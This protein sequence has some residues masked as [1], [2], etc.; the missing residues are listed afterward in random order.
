MREKLRQLIKTGYQDHFLPGTERKVWVMSHF[1]QIVS[2]VTQL[3]WTEGCEVFIKEMAEDDT[4]LIELLQQSIEIIN[5]SIEV[6]RGDLTPLERSKIIALI[7]TD[8]H[9]RDIIEKLATESVSSLQDFLWQ[10]QLRYY[11]DD[12]QDSEGIKIMQVNSEISYGYEYMGAAS[13]LVVT[14]LTERCYLTITSALHIHLGAAPAGPAGTGKTETVKDLSKACAIQCIVFNCSEQMEIKIMARLFSG[15]IQQGAWSCLDEFNRIDIEVLSVIAQQLLMIRDALREGKTEI[16]LNEI[17][18]SVKESVGVF[19]TMNPNYAGRTELPDNLKILFRPIA[20]MIPDYSLIAEILLFAQGFQNA[21]NL[22][23]KMTQ[24]YKLASEQLSQQ[25][26]YD[27]GM[28]A[29][30]SVLVIAGSLKK[31]EPTLSEDVLLI[32]AMRDA[33]VPKFLADDL[34]LFLQLIQDLFPGMDIPE[35][36]YGSLTEEINSSLE[37][38]DYKPGKMFVSKVTQLFESLNVRFGV[39][40]L[41]QPGVGKSACI[42]VLQDSMNH[43]KMKN[44]KD[45]RFQNVETKIIFPK[46]ISLGEL[47]GEESKDTKEWKY[48]IASKLMKKAAAETQ[49]KRAEHMQPSLVSKPS[50]DPE[51]RTWILMDGPVDSKWIENMNSVLDDSRMLCLA[52]AE[53]IKLPTQM[54]ILFEVQDLTCASLATVSRCGMVYICP[55]DVGWKAFIDSWVAKTNRTSEIFKAH[56]ELRH[57]LNEMVEECVEK[58]VN[59]IEKLRDAHA[60]QVDSIQCLESFINFMNFWICKISPADSLDTKK[61]KLMAYFAFSLV[62][63]FGGFI[64]NR[65]QSSFDEVVRP[66]FPKLSIPY[67]G[68]IFDY[69]MEL[70]ES[71]TIRWKHWREFVPQFKFSLNQSYFNLFVPTSDSVKYSYIMAL[72]VEML[73][74]AFF[75]GET[76]V[77]KS[78]M[79]QHLL[80]KKQAENE[81]T[82]TNIVFSA[83]TSSIE[84]QS[85]IEVK[86]EAKKGKKLLGPPGNTKGI[87]F[88]DDVNMP[89]REESGAQPPIEL[90]RQLITYKGFYGRVKPFWT[91]V[92]DTNVIIAAAPPGGGRNILSPRYWIF[93]LIIFDYFIRRNL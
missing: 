81:I 86:M 63:S 11:F 89:V 36:V 56:E 44:I 48:G 33:N 65:N 52:N 41:G 14:P 43:L 57:L 24:L 70:T 21:K 90:L 7:T 39:M 73:R 38:L 92:L 46:A 26:H 60:I 62:W 71:N 15:L 59:T 42:K 22:A 27:F 91:Q 37:R 85:S 66:M 47:Y 34:Q 55:S 75:I 67:S 76:G 1:A 28:R 77:G 13:R 74:P 2:C 51:D 54:R 64:V 12:S 49:K 82:V 87:I 93:F 32:R 88:V 6:I 72:A 19:I 9:W 4:A 35:T 20:M 78:V 3:V 53:R 8:V 79:M 30:K 68:T 25:E 31:M 84:T 58:V 45:P 18:M 61:R 16:V 29:I 5:Q 17:E 10:V 40:V 23:L 83:T 80:M 69:K 50:G